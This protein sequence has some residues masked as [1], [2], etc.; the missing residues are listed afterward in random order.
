MKFE[1]ST[2]YLVKHKCAINSILQ[3]APQKLMETFDNVLHVPFCYT[4]DLYYLSRV[5]LVHRILVANIVKRMNTKDYPIE[6]EAI[7][8]GWGCAEEQDVAAT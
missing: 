2:M 7:Q 3:C 8:I 6:K 4:R 5:E 1:V